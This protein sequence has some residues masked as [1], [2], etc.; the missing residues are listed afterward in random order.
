MPQVSFEAEEGSLWTLM[1]TSPGQPSHNALHHIPETLSNPQYTIANKMSTFI[2]DK[3]NSL[4]FSD[5]HL[6]DNEAEYIHWLV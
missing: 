6:L 5:E 2:H 4:S 1:L 3:L